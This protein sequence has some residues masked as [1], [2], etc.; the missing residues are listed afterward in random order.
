M[1]ASLWRL[2][3]LPPAGPRGPSAPSPDGLFRRCAA[4]ACRPKGGACQAVQRERRGWRAC[5]ACIACMDGLTWIAIGA[6]RIK[7]RSARAESGHVTGPASRP[8]H[9]GAPT[10]PA[11]AKDRT[12]RGIVPARGSRG[13]HPRRAA[14]LGAVAHRPQTRLPWTPSSP[15]R[16]S[17][18]PPK[19]SPSR[20]SACGVAGAR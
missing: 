15:V 19:P 16:P 7:D 1:T 6:A 9:P 3:C 12:P 13:G 17:R 2:P 4:Q 18:G 14:S 20:L 10:R 5:I 11:A 8:S